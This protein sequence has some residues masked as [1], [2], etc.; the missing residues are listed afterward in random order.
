MRSDLGRFAD[1]RKVEIENG[2]SACGA[3]VGG[4]GKEL[5]ALG[6]LPARV[7]WREV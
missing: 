3:A 5:A 2:G 6:V 1:Q 4:K 7:C